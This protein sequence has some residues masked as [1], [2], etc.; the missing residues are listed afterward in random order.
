MHLFSMYKYFRME[1]KEHKFKKIL[2]LFK[3][4]IV[5]HMTLCSQR[6]TRRYIPEDKNPSQPFL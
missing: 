3:S 1:Q 5:R 6:A 2:L 4:T